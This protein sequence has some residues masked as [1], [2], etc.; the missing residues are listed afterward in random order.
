MAVR[1]GVG[2]SAAKDPGEVGIVGLFTLLL[3]WVTGRIVAPL[4][5]GELDADLGEEGDK[6][7][8]KSELC[9]PGVIGDESFPLFESTFNEPKS[10]LGTVDCREGI[11]ARRVRPVLESGKRTG[12]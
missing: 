10:R 4:N 5:S 7:L 11:L 8:G 1:P 3:S 6:G 9:A 2:G 12:L